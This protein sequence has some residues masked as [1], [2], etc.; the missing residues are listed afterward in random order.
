[1]SQT[2]VIRAALNHRCYGL[3]N[4]CIPARTARFAARTRCFSSLMMRLRTALTASCCCC[5]R[6]ATAAARCSGDRLAS[7]RV[8]AMRACHLADSSAD[9]APARLMAVASNCIAPGCR[10]GRTGP[11]T[12]AIRGADHTGGKGDADAVAD[13]SDCLPDGV[14]TRWKIWWCV[15]ASEIQ[16]TVRRRAARNTATAD[17]FADDHAEGDNRRRRRLTISRLAATRPRR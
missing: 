14:D 4:S 6:E 7:A 3:G 10:A 17:G 11:A 12:S 15:P 8:A 13:S 9:A 5:R 2:T 16:G 1:M